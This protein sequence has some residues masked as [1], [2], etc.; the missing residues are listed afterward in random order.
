MTAPINVPASFYFT[1][2][3]FTPLAI[4]TEFPIKVTIPNHPFRPGDAL[5]ATQFFTEPPAAN[6]GMEQLNNRLFYVNL[7]DTDHF[8]LFDEFG[9]GIDGRNYTPFNAIGE[10][11]F[12]LTGPRLDIHNKAV[13]P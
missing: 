5:R 3:Q 9:N 10:A 13:Q 1:T 6:T 2:E 11:Q 12:T 8:H 7:V 4:T